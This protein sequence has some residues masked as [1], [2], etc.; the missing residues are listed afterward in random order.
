MLKKLWVLALVC[1]P[2]FSCN[3]SPAYAGH[4]G[5]NHAFSSR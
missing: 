3:F 2:M 4:S 5:E 1:L